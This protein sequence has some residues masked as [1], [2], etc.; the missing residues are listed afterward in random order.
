M[1]INRI[2]LVDPHITDEFFTPVRFYIKKRR[3]LKKYSYLAN[4]YDVPIVTFSYTNS[5][6]I[7]KKIFSKLPRFLRVFLVYL[8]FILWS[9]LQTEK[10]VVSSLTDGDLAICALRNV[11]ER[12]GHYIKSKKCRIAWLMSHFHIAEGNLK[13]V[14]KDDIILTDNKKTFFDSIDNKIV[15]SP[16]SVKLRF[17][18]KKFKKE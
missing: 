8:E 11:D 13:Y 17:K 15:F 1:T 14:N 4:I 3:A 2:V 16:P 10:I 7:P 6:I 5:G 9:S 12:C 18:N